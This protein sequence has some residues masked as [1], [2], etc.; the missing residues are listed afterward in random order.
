MQRSNRCEPNISGD[1]REIDTALHAQFDNPPKAKVTRSNRVGCAIRY[2]RRNPPFSR[3]KP[4]S[5]IRRCAS[6][7]LNESRRIK[8]TVIAITKE[9]F[10]RGPL[11][12]SV[13]D[14]IIVGKN[15][16]ASLKRM[17]LI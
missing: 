8:C 10:S 7:N 14:H 17:R 11:G 6:H 5:C 13:H 3:C 9:G 12:I 4:S 15:G 16:Q 2:H 1:C